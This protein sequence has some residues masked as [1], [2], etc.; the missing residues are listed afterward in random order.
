MLIAVLLKRNSSAI[1]R[2]EDCFWKLWALF[3]VAK[4]I[5]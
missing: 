5:E 3:L 4:G 2:Q 1:V